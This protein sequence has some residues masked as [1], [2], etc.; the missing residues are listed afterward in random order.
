MKA[1]LLFIIVTTVFISAC[2]SPENIFDAEV[3]ELMLNTQLAEEFITE[4]R[5]ADLPEPVQCYFHY[6][7]LIGKPMSDVSEIIWTERNIKL[8]PDK[9]WTNLETRQYNFVATGSRLA[10]M[11]ARIARPPPSKPASCKKLN[12]IHVNEI[13]STFNH[14]ICAGCLI[15]WSDIQ[16]TSG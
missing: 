4:E 7:G 11:H 12:P 10:Y 14:I 9:P 2:H 1:I 6:T 13:S 8:G 16:P 5:I 3:S 15:K